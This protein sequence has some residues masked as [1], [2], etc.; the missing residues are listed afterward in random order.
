MAAVPELFESLKNMHMFA[1]LNDR[2]IEEVISKI[3]VKKYRKDE[4]ILWQDDTNSY[5]Y[6]VISGRVKVVQTT[7]DGKEIIRAIHNAG[8]SF[9]ELSL[10]DSKTSPAEVKAM[11][12]TTA[13]IISK[14]NFFE[15]IHTQGKV[16]D[17][18]LLMFCG[19]L[20]DSWDRVEMGENKSAIQRITI[21]FHQLSL[22]YGKPITEGI[23]LN[24]RLTHQT[25]ASMTGMT[26]ETVTRG[27]DLLQK[28]TF[29]KIRR[30]DRKIILL[31]GFEKVG[32]V[33]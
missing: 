25:L 28:D 9:G 1:K 20:R 7:E 2:E 6:L 13:A 26:R 8:D 11:Q 22:T 4:V 33:S 29:I 18:L 15:I 14:D 32:I 10:L 24:I 17:N 3:I 12:S 27:L 31:P 5:M 30:P 23:L 19:R 21:L 16:I